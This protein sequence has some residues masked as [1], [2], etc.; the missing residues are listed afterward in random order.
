MELFWSVI[1]WDSKRRIS[2]IRPIYVLP[3]RNFIILWINCDAYLR[4]Y[5]TN[6]IEIY[7]NNWIIIWKCHRSDQFQHIEIVI[8]TLRTKIRVEARV[9]HTI[10]LKWLNFPDKIDFV[11]FSAKI[12]KWCREDSYE[13]M[14][15]QH[16]QLVVVQYVDLI[17]ASCL[18]LQHCLN[19]KKQKKWV[20]S[21]ELLTDSWK[22]CTKIEK[23]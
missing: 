4:T 15:L 7:A 3:N 6:T 10:K 11:F 21:V 16:G 13:F 2:I 1:G 8:N 5:C 22:K 17:Q 23:M 12:I 19:C 20:K 14:H 18:I 9:L